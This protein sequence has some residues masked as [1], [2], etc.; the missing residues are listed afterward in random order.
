MRE[1][2]WITISLFYTKKIKPK[3]FCY[4]LYQEKFCRNVLNASFVKYIFLRIDF[5][6]AKNVRDYFFKIERAIFAFADT[7]LLF[8]DFIDI[9]FVFIFTVVCEYVFV[10]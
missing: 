4:W 7:G 5:K 8:L 3:L 2:N 10:C 6:I 1:T 9:I